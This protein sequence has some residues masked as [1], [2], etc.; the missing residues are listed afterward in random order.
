LFSSHCERSSHTPTQN[1][2]HNYS[3]AYFDLYIFGLKPCRQNDSASNGIKHF[4][5]W[6]CS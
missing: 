2:R 5:T 1:N 4:L 6:M 3:S